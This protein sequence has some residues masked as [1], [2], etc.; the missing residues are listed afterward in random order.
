MSTEKFTV[1]HTV[2]ADGQVNL[3]GLP[4]QRGDTVEITVRIKRARR[5]KR[6]ITV[7]E[8]LASDFV[9]M[10]AN[11]EDIGDTLEFARQLRKQAETRDWSDDDPDG[12]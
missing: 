9:G 2:E 6:G 1:E 5:P 12:Q 4:V 11:R 7:A 10:W 8:L 3:T